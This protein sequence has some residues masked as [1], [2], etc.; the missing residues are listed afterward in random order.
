[1]VVGSSQARLSERLPK[2]L[3]GPFFSG[4]LVPDLFLFCFFMPINTDLQII[5]A[6]KKRDGFVLSV[7]PPP[8]KAST[9]IVSMGGRLPKTGVSQIRQELD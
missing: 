9:G 8:A 6:Y 3:F 4:V 1:M 5:Q 2:L 7:H